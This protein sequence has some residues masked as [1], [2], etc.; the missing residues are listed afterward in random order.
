VMTVVHLNDALSLLPGGDSRTATS[1]AGGNADSLTKADLE[2]TM[3]QMLMVRKGWKLQL[4]PGFAC[5]RIAE[6][7]NFQLSAAFACLQIAADCSTFAL[8]HGCGAAAPMCK[9]RCC[10]VR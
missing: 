4:S 10:A 2:A 3:K 9:R 8:L 6:C 1:A 7:N 5:L